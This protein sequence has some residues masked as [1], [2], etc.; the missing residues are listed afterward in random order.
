MQNLYVKVYLLFFKYILPSFNE[1]NAFFQ[2]K[3]SLISSN[4]IKPKALLAY[5]D[6]IETL[7]IYNPINLLPIKKINVGVTT[8]ALINDLSKTDNELFILKCLKF[9]QKAVS[10][11]FK[12]LPIGNLFYKN[13][14][15]LNRNNIFNANKI[16]NLKSI[17]EIM[18]I[19]INI[20]TH[21]NE[22]KKIKHLK[23]DEALDNTCDLWTQSAEMKN[24]NNEYLFKNVVQVA[25]SALIIPHGSADVE[26]VFS[27]LADTNTKKN[28]SWSYFNF[29]IVKN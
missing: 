13:L 26:C 19:N 14:H 12:R 17:T 11:A 16:S 7:N 2:S 20:H 22:Y 3:K 15:F 27:M 28:L 5:D 6:I 10:E 23:F 1:F 8:R 29:S 18:K 24:F 4:F 25:Q 9:F 21:E